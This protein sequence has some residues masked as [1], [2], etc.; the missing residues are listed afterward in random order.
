ME[1]PVSE[2]QFSTS[3]VLQCRMKF[4]RVGTI[5]SSQQ[6]QLK[7]QISPNLVTISLATHPLNLTPNHY[8]PFPSS[9]NTTSPIIFLTCNHSPPKSSQNYLLVIF[10]PR[11]Y[12]ITFALLDLSQ[13][14]TY[15]HSNPTKTLLLFKTKLAKIN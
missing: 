6:Q 8:F 12:S 14:R 3:K 1:L 2:T 10:A 4:L 7:A 11:K 5:L 9:P 13:T 15:P